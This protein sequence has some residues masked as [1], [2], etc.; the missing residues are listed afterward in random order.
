M[1]MTLN[2]KALGQAILQDKL[3]VTHMQTNCSVH[4]SATVDVKL[5]A[6]DPSVISDLWGGCCRSK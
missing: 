2:T 6:T 5:V 4:Q 3:L 1:T